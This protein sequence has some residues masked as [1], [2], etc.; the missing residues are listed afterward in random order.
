MTTE[1][2]LI[3]K[4]YYQTFMESSENENP[5]KVLGEL[6]NIEQQ[7][8]VADLSY[9]RFAQ[10]EVYFRNKDYE[11]AIFKWENVNN[12]LMPWALK[13]IADAHVALEFLEIAVE[14]Y[15]TVKT[16]SV[17]LKTEVLLQLFSIY[18]QRGKF[19]M[20]ANSIKHAV[21]LNPDYPNVT[22]MARAFFEAQFDFSNAVEL[23]AGEAIR[24]ESLLW[25]DVLH[26]YVVQGDTVGMAPASF[27]EVLMTLYSVNQD[28]FENLLA[29][30]WRSCEQNDSSLEWLKE[31]N[32]LLLEINPQPLHP[33][34]KLTTLYQGTY[35]ALMD[36][37]RLIEDLSA[38]IPNHVTNWLKIT[39]GSDAIAA[40]SAVLTWNEL[41]P[42]WLDE[43]IVG[44]AERLMSHSRLHGVGMEDV[45]PVFDS[46]RKWAK[47]NELMLGMQEE[48]LID[49]L[50]DSNDFHMMITGTEAVGKSE[51]VN[52]LLGREISNESTPATVLFKHADQTEIQG[53]TDQ[54]V[55]AITEQSDLEQIVEA[56]QPL[57]SYNMP[58]PF[59]NNNMLTLIDTPAV[60]WEASGNALFTYLHLADGLLFV[61]DASSLQ[62]YHEIELA[63]KIREQAPDLPIH[64]LLS[65]LQEN[66]GHEVELDSLEK[67]TA[68][69]HTYF[70]SSKVF[71]Y[72]PLSNNDGEVEEITKFIQSMVQGYN[73]EDGIKH[74]IL[75]F[76]K[77][78]IQ[79]LLE[80]RVEMENTLVETIKWNED[81]AIKLD[82]A[83]HQ[84]TDLQEEKVQDIKK[85]YRIIKDNVRQELLASIPNLLA[86]CAKLVKEDS[87][88][89][90]IHATLNDEMNKQIK[91]Y[92]DDKA[93]PNVTTA[94]RE[95]VT[96]SE[97]DFKDSQEYLD[98]MA[99]SINQLE[100]GEKLHLDCDFKVLDDWRRDI[101]RMTSGSVELE[102]INIIK[103][104]AS[105]QFIMKNA[106]KLFGAIIKNKGMLQ[107]KYKQ[108]I[109]SKDYSNT[110]A[111]ITNTFMQQFEFFEKT[112]ERD[113]KMFFANP[114]VV[115]NK[116]V[117]DKQ[118][119]I[120]ANEQSL[121]KMRENPE[122]Y[123]DPL[124]LFQLKIRQ[125]EWIDRVPGTFRVSSKNVEYE[126]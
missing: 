46:I 9:L 65:D 121:N 111:T 52:K 40:A 33:W 6:F 109:Q 125:Y 82:G 116:A 114:H 67:T 91:N 75:H 10:G 29:A 50:V 89:D 112:L 25:F 48:W 88:F 108:F 68:W 96:T 2:L 122:V 95:W 90:N 81:M 31:I 1:K 113:I 66:D 110:A 83:I 60:N 57:I 22:D 36:G 47:S 54:E 45:F 120:Q 30:I 104:S 94:T 14:Y 106:D 85:N 53:I 79:L 77:H 107:N 118:Q 103:S 49:E 27:R 34:K 26:S 7:K 70:P 5:I 92:L 42:K 4:N 58:L 15:Q 59:L 13:N 12:E 55:R 74:K 97:E 63:I 124:T 8:E 23:A 119:E 78:L 56:E 35:D 64:F 16:D 98:E 19:E 73:S 105:S 117:E 24:T 99:E 80:K 100:S 37:N 123:T 39:T 101:D 32:H 11:A 28:R 17:D 41:Y 102:K 93:L 20:A 3:D 38:Y 87:D 51:L 76:S 126:H 43:T 44:E 86:S 69:I 62:T 72:R 71:V 61:M 18:K 115:L 84:L 21:E